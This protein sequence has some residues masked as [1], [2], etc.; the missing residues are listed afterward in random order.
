M[1]TAAVEEVVVQPGTY[2]YD[3]SMPWKTQPRQR[4]NATNQTY[5]AAS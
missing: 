1:C 2:L 5:D 3:Q 4:T